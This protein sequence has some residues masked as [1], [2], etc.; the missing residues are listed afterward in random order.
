MQDK[1]KKLQMIHSARKARELTLLKA[2]GYK[3]SL[4]K[5]K[6][7]EKYQK[8]IKHKIKQEKRHTQ[9][10]ASKLIHDIVMPN[11]L[12][13]YNSCISTALIG[14]LI[15]NTFRLYR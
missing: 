1:E 8:Q 9:L 6:E 13:D 11:K 5:K 7:L 4:M 10:K 14:I 15:T 12:S 2:L 3:I